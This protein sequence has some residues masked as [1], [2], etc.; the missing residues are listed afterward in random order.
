MSSNNFFNW[1]Y[2]NTAI[3]YFVFLKKESEIDSLECTHD[4]KKLL[5]IEKNIKND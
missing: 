5:E 1:L 4:I 3:L 2:L